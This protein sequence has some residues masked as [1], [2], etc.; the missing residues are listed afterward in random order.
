MIYNYFQSE[1]KGKI[2]K[3]YLERLFSRLY[4]FNNIFEDRRI[5]TCQGFYQNLKV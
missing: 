1:K 3:K 4:G 2:G 5:K